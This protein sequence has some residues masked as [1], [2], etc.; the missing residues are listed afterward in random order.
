[1]IINM[2]TKMD[3]DEDDDGNGD[4]EGEDGNEDGEGEG[5]DEED[6]GKYKLTQQDRST[7]RVSH[8]LKEYQSHLS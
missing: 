6:K 4:G 8:R 2:C 3:E 7:Q 1:M 5:G